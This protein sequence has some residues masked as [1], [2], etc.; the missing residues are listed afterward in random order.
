MPLTFTLHVAKKT[1]SQQ[2]KTFLFPINF[3]SNLRKESAR[4]KTRKIHLPLFT[5]QKKRE[6]L[7]IIIYHEFE[8]TLDLRDAPLFHAQTCRKQQKFIVNNY[9]SNIVFFLSRREI[10]S[11]TYTILMMMMT[12]LFYPIVFVFFNRQER[13]KGNFSQIIQIAWYLSMCLDILYLLEEAKLHSLYNSTYTNNFTV[14]YIFC[15]PEIKFPMNRLSAK[16]PPFLQIQLENFRFIQ[17]SKLSAKISI[18]IIWNSSPCQYVCPSFFCN[19]CLFKSMENIS[20][21]LHPPFNLKC[22]FVFKAID[23]L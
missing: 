13:R 12:S 4:T 21:R 8:R 5:R 23:I 7:L 9:L 20:A 2:K 16:Y 15:V 10:G 22:I 17:K 6:H 14:S 18:S 3:K 1:H 19:I 11:H